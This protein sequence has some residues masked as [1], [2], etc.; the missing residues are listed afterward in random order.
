[1]PIELRNEVLFSSLFIET[2]EEDSDISFIRLKWRCM[3]C[4]TSR[5]QYLLLMEFFPI[6]PSQSNFEGVFAGG[7][8]P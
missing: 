1:M 8:P 6:I 7:A 4:V 3:E 5:G 2:I